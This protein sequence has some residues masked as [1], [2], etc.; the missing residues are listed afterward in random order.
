[1]CFDTD[2]L[3][4]PEYDSP[5]D[6][7]RAF[8][9]LGLRVAA[10]IAQAGRPI[11]LMAGGV[12]EQFEASPERRYFSEILYLALV[13]DD[14]VL[15]RR[16]RARPTWRQSGSPHVIE[17]ER[18]FNRWLSANASTTVPP[19]TVLDT[20][21]TSE[22]DTVRRVAAWVRGKAPSNRR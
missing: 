22:Q 18:S 3:W 17:Q 2:I 21:A 19:M 8:R 14:A 13:C 10:H 15:V 1:M 16:L 11:V 6:D 20:S 4:R 5:E 9:D 7:Y 12:P